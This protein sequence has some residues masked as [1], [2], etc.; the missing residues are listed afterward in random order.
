MRISRLHNSILFLLLLAAGCRGFSYDSPLYADE[1]PTQMFLRLRICASAA[2]STRAGDPAA[3]E[4]GDGRESAM[5]RENRVT[6]LNLYFYNP[7]T[8]QPA[9]SNPFNTSNPETVLIKK[10]IYI[11][12]E[13]SAGFNRTDYSDNSRLTSVLANIL[14]PLEDYMPEEGDCVIVIANAGALDTPGSLNDLK[15]MICASS[16]RGEAV[17]AT[18][19][20]T[21]A[22]SRL[23]GTNGKIDL[24]PKGTEQDP[25][26][27]EATIERAAARL[28]F[29]FENDNLPGA[30]DTAQLIYDVEG[31]SGSKVRITHIMPVNNML[32]AS[33]IF[34]HVTDGFDTDRVLVC[35]D[36]TVDDKGLPSNY[37]LSPNTLLSSPSLE[38]LYGDSRAESVRRQ[39]A[40]ADWNEK[41]SIGEI[42]KNGETASY[43]EDGMPFEKYVILSY[44]N[45]NTIKGSDF[46]AE[47]IT[48]LAI[49]AIYQPG[50]VYSGYTP[51]SGDGGEGLAIDET[52]FSVGKDFWAVT[53]LNMV[54][55]EN[56][57]G[58]RMNLY[59]SN[60][61][62]ADAYKAAHPGQNCIIT[63]FDGGVCY[64]NLWLRHADP[65]DNPN[66][67][68][69]MKY[70][71]VRNN[72]YRVG[73]T[74]SGPGDP[75]P[76][77][78]EPN[79]IKSYIFVRKWNFRLQP[80]INL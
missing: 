2:A 25:F 62:A 58:D 6:D 45:E 60:E 24:S 17:N 26:S 47:R 11:S 23:D 1:D 63:K 9:T 35:S 41:Y 72:I 4:E 8:S 80:L 21:M 74:F 65:Q 70:A 20:F 12:S 40:V 76:E 50:V 27:A 18:S 54:N 31:E 52:D 10:H 55:K 44:A 38:T 53:I 79:H 49:R 43:S 68:F 39:N 59:F 71:V 13:L 46:S 78:R 36:E 15:D 66:A 5:E 33:Y 77:V 37:V 19:Y 14:I 42:L 16:W 69:P 22:T 56:T 64:F 28:D 57:Y 73:V 32:K 29:W 67:D 30:G 61:N 34:K 7:S 48:G 75:A 3:G 51:A